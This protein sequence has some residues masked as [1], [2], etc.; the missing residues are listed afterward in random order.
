M[1][2]GGFLPSLLQNGLIVQTD[3]SRQ[4]AAGARHKG[5]TA[6]VSGALMVTK[7]DI[8]HGGPTVDPVRADVPVPPW[9]ISPWELG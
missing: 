3:Y 4:M 8:S 5:A 1:K 6:A 7:P 2:H 9:L